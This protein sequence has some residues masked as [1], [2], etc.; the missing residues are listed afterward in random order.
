MNSKALVI[1]VLAFTAVAAV[2]ASEGEGE[3]EAEWQPPRP[4][5]PPQQ[6]QQ[7]QHPGQPQGQR[8]GVPTPALPKPAIKAGPKKFTCVFFPGIG[9]D[10]PQLDVD[11]PKRATHPK[12]LRRSYPSYWGDQLH[13]KL[14]N[15]CEELWFYDT[16]THYRPWNDP[17]LVREFS[18]VIDQQKPHV[19]FAHGMGN[20]VLA[21]CKH[22]KM[23][24]C[25][26]LGKKIDWFALQP[27]LR[28][29]D[30]PDVMEKLC[31]Q[32]V[33][34]EAFKG[35]VDCIAKQPQNPAKPEF[36]LADAWKALVP[37][38]V[39]KWVYQIAENDLS[40]E[41]CGLAAADYTKGVAADAHG[42][43]LIAK[44]MASHTPKGLTSRNSRYRP[45]PDDWKVR[46]LVT[47]RETPKYGNDGVVA[48]SSCA[49]RSAKKFKK[50]AKS[51]W[52]ALDG[53]HD[54]GTCS[55]GETQMPSQQP[56]EWVLNMVDRVRKQN[57]FPPARFQQ[58][59][60]DADV[61]A[62]DAA[63]TEA[64]DEAE[65]ESEDEIEAEAEADAE[66]DDE[67][68]EADAIEA[69]VDADEQLHGDA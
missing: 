47:A 22:D 36:D 48:F 6:Q 62:V 18:R 20:L 58:I 55:S 42:F 7:Q 54:Y 45:D 37:S 28:G 35:G 25:K 19:V 43:G 9:I 17:S 53:D 30:V 40:G 61:E 50:D 49:V 4:G 8:P 56:C 2:A 31:P 32:L 5:Q 23:D 39:P 3:V 66:A 10:W 44:A 16:D 24:G 33:N 60:A 63:D 27:M 68:A 41:M 11:E 52:Y 14:K 67:L 15:K 65:D 26:D 34:D 46:N 51:K 38:Q 69:E 21:Q 57:K 13:A 12:F 29:T 64:D 59:G 1:A